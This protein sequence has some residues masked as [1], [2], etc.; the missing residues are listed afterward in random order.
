[1]NRIISIKDETGQYVERELIYA[2]LWWHK[3]GLQQTASG[4]GSKLTT[5]YKIQYQGR[6]R[7]V[8]A[9]LYSNR[10]VNYVIV[11]NKHIPI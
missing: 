8:Y 2:P 4:Y 9:R 5:P 10:G 11:D 7:R 6:L 3:Q 1:M